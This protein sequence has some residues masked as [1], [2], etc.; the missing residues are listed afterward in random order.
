MLIRFLIRGLQ[1]NINLGVR[2][3]YFPPPCKSV[4]ES[5]WFRDLSSWLFFHVSFKNAGY[6][7]TL[8]HIQSNHPGLFRES[9]RHAPCQESSSS[10]RGSLS[11]D[12]FAETLPQ[13]QDNIRPGCSSIH[14][15]TWWLDRFAFSKTSVDQL[16]CSQPLRIGV[17]GKI[18]W[19]LLLLYAIRCFH[20][21]R[22][23]DHSTDHSW[24]CTWYP[25]SF[26]FFFG[27]ILTP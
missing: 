20:R 12:Y 11:D 13:L 24:L 21:P 14:G 16:D 15:S 3:L 5:F 27:L 18:V 1:L 4:W 8:V 9:G 26:L 10:R 7:Q 23:Y 19:F 2:V 22:V 17:L 25:L 6:P